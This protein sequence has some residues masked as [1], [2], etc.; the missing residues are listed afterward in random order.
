M[1]TQA[2]KVLKPKVRISYDEMEAWLY[3][4]KP[5]GNTVY[6]VDSLVEILAENGVRHG[7]DRGELERIIKEPVYNWEVSVAKGTTEKDGKN[8]YFE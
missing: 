8:G 3:L 2:V 4:P 5:E 6:T 1:D 7:V